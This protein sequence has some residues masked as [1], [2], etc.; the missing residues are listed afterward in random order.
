MEWHDHTDRQ[1]EGKD[2]RARKAKPMGRWGERERVET[3]DEGKKKKKVARKR[4][5]PG[6]IFRRRE[7]LQQVPGRASQASFQ[8]YV[9]AARS[10]GL[11]WNEPKQRLPSSL[12]RVATND[13]PHS[14]ENSSISSGFA[15]SG[16]WRIF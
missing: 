14:D 9:N 16:L 13:T 4:G 11:S 8:H 10:F 1:R 6:G 3:N 5:Q 15:D 7:E 2:E 12:Y